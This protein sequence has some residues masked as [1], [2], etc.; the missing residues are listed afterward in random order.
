M[1]RIEK[2]VVAYTSACHALNHI[3]ELA[4]GVVLIGIAQEFGV[5]L[6]LLGVLANIAGFA[7]GLMS[8]P[9]GFLADR[10]SE[11]RLLIIF[12]L[13]S[14]VASIA[15]GL[16]PNISVLGVALAVLG[17]VLGIFHP[18]GSA[19]IARAT[20]HKGVAFGYLGMSGNL[21][22]ALGPILA[23]AIAS[24][25]GW[26]AS[27]LIFAIPA[28]LL[29]GL[30]YFFARTE[31]PSVSEET[32]VGTDTGETHLYLI[33]LPL[34][35]IFVASAVN[36]FIYR[37]LITF[38]PL[39]LSQRLHFTFFNLDSMALAGSFTTVALI[40]GILGQF[41][42]GYLSER[43]RRE[44]LALVVAIVSTPLLLL[45][46]NSGGLI[47]MLAA[48][49]FAFFHFMGQPIYNSLIANYSPVSWRGRS[50]G[51]S[52]FCI[53]GIGSFS[54]TILGYTAEQLGIN[55]AF[56]VMAGI[57]LATI[58]CMVILLVRAS[59]ISK[60]GNAYSPDSTSG[61]YENK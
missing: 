46:G 9:A 56:I 32:D 33:V 54:A 1:E 58:A 21:G 17:L 26:R 51:I 11:R 61:S 35:L 43:R 22:V 20:K 60:H 28:F 27:Y 45:M 40:F 49:S 10:I 3:F 47:L 38:L 15:V 53:F 25:M 48:I 13:G 36:G 2:Q 12:C 52:N 50:Y 16:S 14:G 44:V 5:G 30:L 8:L 23:G 55:W 42:G 4:Y 59:T 34:V 24:T 57:S 29:A 31:A 19:F 6:F 7:F 37:G 18:V 39:Y 41:L